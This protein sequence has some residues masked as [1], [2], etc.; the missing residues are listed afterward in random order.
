VSEKIR[1]NAP[2][3]VGLLLLALALVIAMRLGRNGTG[4]AATACAFFVIVA[5]IGLIPARYIGIGQ[6]GEFASD[7]RS[8]LWGYQAAYD[9]ERLIEATD[10]PDSRTL[11]WATAYGFPIVQW[12]NLPHQGGGISNSEKPPQTLE[13]LTTGEA[14]LVHHPTTDEILLLSSNP[15]DMDRGVRALRRNAAKPVV[16]RRGVWGHGNL[17]YALVDVAGPRQ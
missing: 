10:Q 2:A 5:A 8:E 16:R 7:G 15:A 9:M 13:R 11:L 4:R 6:T 3:V 12:T 17:Y 14:D 1:D